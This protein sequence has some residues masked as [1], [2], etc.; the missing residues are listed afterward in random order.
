MV[1]EGGDK[2]KNARTN[3]EDRERRKEQMPVTYLV[4]RTAATMRCDVT[5]PEALDENDTFFQ[6]SGDSDTI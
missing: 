3:V 1:E 6:G 5:D 2:V 4:S